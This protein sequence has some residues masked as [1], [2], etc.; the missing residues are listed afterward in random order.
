MLVKDIMTSKVESIGPD[1]FLQD[2]ARKMR[3]LKIGSL[4]VWQDGE[5]LGMITD[6]DICCR[7]VAEGRD[8]TKTRVRDV[9]S[10]NPAYCFDDQDVAD[11]AHVMEEKHVRRLAVLSR[12]KAM[13]GCCRST[14]GAATR[15]A[16]ESQDPALSPISRR[17]GGGRG[18]RAR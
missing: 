16:G 3:D 11:A 1:F 2:V 10:K 5:L 17:R 15:L 4:P 14:T 12:S 6:R 8:P 13:V 9:M 18:P 7:A